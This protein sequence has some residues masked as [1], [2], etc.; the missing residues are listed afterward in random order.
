MALLARD[1]HR[2]ALPP[3]S[4]TG[5]SSACAL[6]LPEPL[7]S[8][9][10]A[11]LSF[12][13]GEWVVRDLGS[14]NGTWVNGERMSP[15]S[16]RPLAA[17]D[18]LA[19]GDPAN[20][21]TLLDA[22]PPVAMARRVS[23]GELIAADREILALPS[24]ASPLASVFRGD[25]GAFT[26]EVEGQPREV[27][28]GDAVQI[29]GEVFV[30]HLP[31]YV[32]ATAQAEER[33][34]RLDEVE[35]RFRVSRDEE[36]VEVS[37][38]EAGPKVR[39]LAPRTHHY[40]LVL[41]ARARIRDQRAPGLSEAQ[42]GWVFVDELCRMLSVDENRLN[43]DIYRVRQEMTSIGLANPAAIIERRRGSKQLRLGTERA[44]I[45]TLD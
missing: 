34:P 20:E 40:T 30:L 19:F 7:V 21:W 6:K 45:E 22:S 5:R 14:L 2:I 10:H 3:H 32:L 36:T 15:G 38:A 28:D 39:A 8:A 24:Q 37:V 41:L 1:E 31:G 9:E 17:G 42:R 33:K 26:M 13:N 43:V 18:R 29:A 23:T 11:S 35:I 27:R 44:V 16:A 4:V 25:D 12:R